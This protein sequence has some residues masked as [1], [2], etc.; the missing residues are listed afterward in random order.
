MLDRTYRR[1]LLLFFGAAVCLLFSSFSNRVL[2]QVPE[3]GFSR[4][5]GQIEVGG[6]YAGAEFHGSRPLPTSIAL[7]YPVANI[8][9]LSADYWRRGEE[10][11]PMVLGV[12]LGDSPPLRLGNEPWP[13]TRSPHR[14]VFT[15]EREGIGYRIDYAFCLNEPAMVFTLTATNHRAEPIPLE[16]YTHLVLSLRTSHTFA[17][18]DSALTWA[19]P[20]GSSLVAL[21]PYTDTD[22][23]SVFVLNVGEQ[24]YL[25]SHDAG[26]LGVSDTGS[27]SWFSR[28]AGSPISPSLGEGDR[29]PAVAAFF[30]RRRLAPGDSLVIRQLIGSARS[31]AVASTMGRLKRKWAAEVSAYD[32]LLRSHASLGAEFVTG[33]SWVDSSARWATSLLAANAHYLD[34]E[35][36]PMPCPV[37]YHFFFT[38]DLLLTDLGAVMVDP[39][40]VRRDLLYLKKI[41]TESLLAHAYYWK[42]GRYVT[43]WCEPDNWNHLWFVILSAAYL[44]HTLD[45]VTVAG[46]YPLMKRSLESILT[47]K[48]GDDLMYARRP[49]WWDIGQWEGPRAYITLLT[50]RAIGDFLFTSAMLRRNEPNLLELEATAAAMQSAL[51]TRLWDEE[52][53][54][55]FN[56]NGQKLDRHYYMG[57]LLAAVYGL[58]DAERELRLVE[59][60]QKQLLD[61]RIGVRIV[62]PPD[63]HL[64]SVRAL[65]KFKGNEAGDPYFYANGGV[66][67]HANAWFLMGL[68]RTGRAEDAWSLF[69]TLMTVEGISAS[70]MGHPAMYEYR[71]A[72]PASPRYGMIDKPSFL[73]AGGFYLQ[74]LLALLGVEEGSW[75]IAI[76]G[77]RARGLDSVS[78]PLFYGR[79][80]RVRLNGSGI[81]LER[82]DAGGRVV[83]SRVVPTEISSGEDG[84]IK[85]PHWTIEFGNVARPQLEELSAILLSARLDEDGTRLVL[86]L[87]SFGGHAARAAVRSPLSPESVL[88]DGQKVQG[89]SRFDAISRSYLT[90]VSFR[91]SDD[92]QVLEFIY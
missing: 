44:R 86:R 27:S 40:R 6:P 73:W 82:F 37:E 5:Y 24:A 12:K 10:S 9:D 29:G 49:D 15:S 7:F 62:H 64:D 8:I 71:Y 78:F 59:T 39:E 2:A 77:A 66:W 55:L 31:E 16:L 54:Y 60:A 47:Q 50:I 13:N 3:F 48:R 87:R 69:R 30:Y 88:L 76:G 63:F 67:P 46:L 11:F 41:S 57:S 70:P 28:D 81:G 51:R 38:H 35:V 36:V 80:R 91:G 19:E 92:E 21:F 65:Y 34:G 89:S 43:E 90:V 26:S 84:E 58:L 53:G 23:T 83:P 25:W 56:Y 18:K 14:V 22:S 20:D 72:D 79:Q 74:T 1:V 52:A 45:S 68:H 61:S 85:E 42:D 75:N 32:S 17:R 4:G 33:D